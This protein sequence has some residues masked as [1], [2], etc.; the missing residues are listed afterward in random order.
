MRFN[1]KFK[2]NERSNHDRYLVTSKRPF[3][4]IGNTENP[5]DG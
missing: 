2:N 5:E 3:S 4:V 1:K